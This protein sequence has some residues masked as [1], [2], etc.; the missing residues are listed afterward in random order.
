MHYD[1]SIPMI[2]GSLSPR[3]IASLR[4]RWRRRPADMKGSCEYI[5]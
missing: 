5:E 4:Y 3:H 2:C 1:K